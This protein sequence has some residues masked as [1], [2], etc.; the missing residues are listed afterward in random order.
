L[1]LIMLMQLQ[2]FLVYS[3][4]GCRAECWKH[5]LA[6]NE[7]FAFPILDVVAGHVVCLHSMPCL[8][9]TTVNHGQFWEVQVRLV[10][11]VRLI[12]EGM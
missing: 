2:K 5:G 4:T 3:S 9:F 12:Q 7:F 6:V 11:I 1:T 10:I 8:I